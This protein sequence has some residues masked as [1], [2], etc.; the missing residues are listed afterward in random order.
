MKKLK[1]KL[2]LKKL[3]ISRLN[4]MATINGGSMGSIAGETDDACVTQKSNSCPPGRSY[5]DCDPI[6][7]ISFDQVC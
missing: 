2:M 3:T 5:F 4:N 7:I 6:P 1:K